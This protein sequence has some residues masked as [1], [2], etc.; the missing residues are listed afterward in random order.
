M[1]TAE[2]QA[3]PIPSPA[4]LVE[5]TECPLCGSSSNSLFESIAE[6]ERTLT[7]CMCGNCGTVYQ[8]PRMT[9][10]AL[11]TYYEAEYV[12][13]H[14]HATGV[15]EKELRIQA[16]RARDLAQ[17]LRSEISSVE[18]H[19]DIG[20]STGSLML[21]I[22]Q[23][24]GNEAIGIEPAEV[25]RAYC[26]ARGLRVVPDLQSLSEGRFDL[27]TMA[28]VVEH[29]PDPVGYLQAVREERLTADGT[30]LVEVPNLY[31]HP[32]VEIPHLFCFSSGT[33]SYAL[34][35]AGYEVSHM[36]RHG[37]PRSKLIPLYLT[38]I[39]RPAGDVRPRKPGPRLVRI[40][41]SIGMMWNR[42]AS[43]V[44]PGLAWLP[45]PSLEGELE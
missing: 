27:I 7:Y 36:V 43:R 10:S 25:Y 18:R 20:S 16:G 23:A 21:A 44:A 5:V 32:S 15:T 42:A 2:I 14:Q 45:L 40:K 17:R 37:S 22:K 38:A 19:L 34:A 39:A 35:R 41:R 33:L 29:L 9:D 28:H 26:E 4:E 31:G 13:Q 3:D 11:E 12:A 8:S 6:T 1:K 24:Y 30:L